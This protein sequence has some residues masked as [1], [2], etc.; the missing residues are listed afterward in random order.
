MFRANLGNSVKLP[1]KRLRSR[2]IL[3]AAYLSRG[4]FLLVQNGR[5]VLNVSRTLC[6]T[7]VK[8]VSQHSAESRTFSLSPAVSSHRKSSQGGLG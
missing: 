8:R 7:H 1:Y 6:S 5:N 3:V 2:L 4:L